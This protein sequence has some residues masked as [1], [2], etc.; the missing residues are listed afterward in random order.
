VR[1]LQ[2]Q[3]TGTG[4]AVSSYAIS[5]SLPTGLSFNT[6]TGAISGT[7]NNV[8]VFGISNTSGSTQT[9]YYGYTKV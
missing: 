7:T 3:P 8:F 1:Q 6:T 5:P 2:I 9:V 4:V